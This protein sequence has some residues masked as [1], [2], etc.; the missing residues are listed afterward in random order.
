M[1]GECTNAEKLCRGGGI[2]LPRSCQVYLWWKQATGSEETYAHITC[3]H[4]WTSLPVPRILPQSTIYRIDLC[5]GHVRLGH[6][7]DWERASC[8]TPPTHF[9]KGALDPA[10]RQPMPARKTH[11]LLL[12][13]TV[14]HWG[15]DFCTHTV[16][17]SSLIHEDLE[18]RR[19]P[20]R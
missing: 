13:L 5:P 18:R 10:A 16:F 9:P 15:D 1:K 11:L 19:H 4:T 14:R 3:T 2:C 20:Q 17:I 12:T 8:S 7:Y 6:R